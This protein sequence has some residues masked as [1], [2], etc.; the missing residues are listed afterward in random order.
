MNNSATVVE[1]NLFEQCDG[2]IEI[3]SSKS[4]GNIYRFNTFANCA[5]MLTLR[6]GNRC[7]VEGN[8][9]LGHHKKGS[10]GIRIIG[11]EHLII[12]NYLDGLEKGGFWITSGI[13]NSPL[14]GYFQ[15]KNCLIA[16]NTFVDSAGPAIELDAGIGS[17]NR[18]LRPDY[19]VIANNLFSPSRGALLKGMEGSNYKWIAN[20]AAQAASEET[21]AEANPGLRHVDPKLAHAPDGLWRPAKDSPVRGAA[22]G[23]FPHIKTDIDGQERKAA[24]D[25]GCDQIA[26]SPIKNR[27]LTSADV[28]PAW[29]ERPNKL[30]S[31]P[32]GK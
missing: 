23:N 2:E 10:G 24:L 8:F 18:T 13:S 20:I 3:I 22:E 4:C 9:F 11:E 6:H 5:G 15:A 21:P 19:I 7:T 1:L 32:P 31:E 30:A 14:N 29:L 12:N 26:D 27:P 28:G 16:F 25:V 17:A